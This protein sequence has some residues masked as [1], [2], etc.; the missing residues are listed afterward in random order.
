M[1]NFKLYVVIISNVGG[2]YVIGFISVHMYI[3]FTYIVHDYMYMHSIRVT[4]R[5]QV[6]SKK[7][8]TPW[9]SRGE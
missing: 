5:A 8:R 3:Y 1:F 6:Q 2:I 9:G 4:F 7:R